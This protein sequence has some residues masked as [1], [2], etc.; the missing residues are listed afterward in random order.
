MKL[1]VRLLLAIAALVATSLTPG[2]RAQAAEET[3]VGC[4]ESALRVDANGRGHNC[5]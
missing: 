1:L 5:P 3:C 2:G 4:F